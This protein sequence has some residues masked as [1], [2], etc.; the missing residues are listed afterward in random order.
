MIRKLNFDKVEQ[1]INVRFKN[2]D[3]LKQALTHRSFLNEH[4]EWA[5][6]GHNEKLEFLG[7]AVAE[8]V[9]TEYLYK[10]YPQL[11]EG[12]LTS[13]RAALINSNALFEAA[14]YRPDFHGIKGVLETVAGLGVN[15]TEK[16]LFTAIALLGLKE[17]NDFYSNI[18]EEINSELYSLEMML[19]QFETGL[20]NSKND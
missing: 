15:Y 11:Q 20:I 14:E 19:N 10:K 6:I 2:I 7:D 3:L 4:S 1:I 8:L 18:A 17:D 9:T 5:S 16:D 12:E 13:L